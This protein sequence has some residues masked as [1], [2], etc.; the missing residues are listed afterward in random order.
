MDPDDKQKETKNT[1][2]LTGCVLDGSHVLPATGIRFLVQDAARLY[3][4]L[5]GDRWY[6]LLSVRILLVL[7]LSYFQIP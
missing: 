5:L 2:F 3:W 1:S 6:I 7:L 4:E